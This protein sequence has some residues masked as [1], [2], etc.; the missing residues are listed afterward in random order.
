M[1]PIIR[2][3][4]LEMSSSSPAGGK[5][6]G[7]PIA[8]R[9]RKGPILFPDCESTAGR[10]CS[11]KEPTQPS[12]V[13]AGFSTTA[14]NVQPASAITSG[15]RG[16]TDVYILGLATDYCVKF[17]AVDAVSLKFR[18]FVVLDVCRG[19]DLKPGDVGTL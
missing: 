1:P 11:K 18:T 4:T 10:P 12:T 9:R 6:S 13:T 14:S 8:C 19:V 17:T 7:G 15:E 16:I 2:I 3:A 5:Y